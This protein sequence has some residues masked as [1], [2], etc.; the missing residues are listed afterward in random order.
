MSTNNQE[1]QGSIGE[2]L[3]DHA[4]TLISILIIALLIGTGIY[5]YTKNDQT[6]N[7]ASDNQSPSIAERIQN[8]VGRDTSEKSK[9]KSDQPVGPAKEQAEKTDIMDLVVEN[10]DKSQE[11]LEGSVKNGKVYSYKA[12]LGDGVTHLA[13][14]AVAEYLKENP[15]DKIDTAH[16]IFMET[17]LKDMNYKASLDIGEQVN[18]TADQLSQVVTEAQNLSTSQINT[19][20]TYVHLVP[21]LK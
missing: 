21:S 8:I 12:E 18:F 13:R 5:A 16:K 4:R 14:K 19:W 15:N 17:R 7:T 11:I 2:F 9:D 10:G 20:N 3:T 6:S 1:S